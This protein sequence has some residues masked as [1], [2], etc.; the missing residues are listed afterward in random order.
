MS[1]HLL[2]KNIFFGRSFIYGAKKG[3]FFIADAFYMKNDSTQMKVDGG[4]ELFRFCGAS[5]SRTC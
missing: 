4:K 1:K 3:D 2:S 5:A